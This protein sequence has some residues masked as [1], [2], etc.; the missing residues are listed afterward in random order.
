M[1]LG[2][3]L[4]ASGTQAESEVTIQLMLAALLRRA[5]HPS[6]LVREQVAW[7]LAPIE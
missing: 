1:A 6:A 3:A 7:A 4:H 5:D 2:N